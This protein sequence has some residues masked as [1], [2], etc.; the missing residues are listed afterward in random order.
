MVIIFIL[1]INQIN[2]NNN[3]NNFLNNHPNHRLQNL[4]V[5]HPLLLL[6]NV[7]FLATLWA[8]LQFDQPICAP[9]GCLLIG[10]HLSGPAT[11]ANCRIAFYAKVIQ[12]M[13]S[14]PDS[15]SALQIYKPKERTASVDRVVSD[16]EVIGINLL[17]KGVS[18]Q[19]VG[20][21]ILSFSIFCERDVI[22]SL[23]DW[24]WLPKTEWREWSSLPLERRENSRL[25]S[26]KSTDWRR[27]IPSLFIL[28]D[29]FS[30][31]RRR[32][33]R[34]RDQDIISVILVFSKLFVRSWKW[35]DPDIRTN[36]LWLSSSHAFASSLPSYFC[37]RVPLQ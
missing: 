16:M 5:F 31:R 36:R 25:S 37:G 27:M 26:E 23:S 7:S 21:T 6:P 20:K 3:N 35:V 1:F 32:S 10:S 9:L 33:N 14:E 13:S 28:D 12:A 24:K 15:L 18:V 2:N 29:I 19:P 34:S 8:F 30:T 22:P 17:D 4:T 11:D